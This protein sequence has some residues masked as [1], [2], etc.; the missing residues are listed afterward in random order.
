M[1]NL[2]KPNSQANYMKTNDLALAFKVTI[3]HSRRV[4]EQKHIYGKN[5][6]VITYSAAFT[7]WQAK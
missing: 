3:K 6:F 1:C 4:S 7:S 5:N 2:S